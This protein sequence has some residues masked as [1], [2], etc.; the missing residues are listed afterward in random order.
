M[1]PELI[2]LAPVMFQALL[3]IYESIAADPRTPEE[4]RQIYAEI[5]AEMAQMAPL[6]QAAPT[7]PPGSGRVEEKSAG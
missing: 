4:Q 5:A 3:K 6:V 1:G 2:L 7:P